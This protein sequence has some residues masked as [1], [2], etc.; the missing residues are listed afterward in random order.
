MS[1]F[2][3]LDT[4]DPIELFAAQIRRSRMAVK[5]AYDEAFAAWDRRSE[6]LRE[7]QLSSGYG[8]M[9]PPWLEGYG[10]RPPL[11]QVDLDRMW[12]DAVAE[13]V[14]ADMQASLVVL[15][16]DDALQRLMRGLLG[17]ERRPEGYGPEYGVPY[18]GLV[19]LTVLL[20]AGSNS[21]RHVSEWDD[22][23]WNTY[24]PW[25][26]ATGGVYPTLDE[27]KVLTKIAR[28]QRDIV[29]RMRL[30]MQSIDVF[31]RVFG[32]GVNKRIR[33]P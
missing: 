5:S 10:G 32:I 2:I 22:L 18:K 19:K 23:P 33:D 1:G 24:Y 11:A 7:H 12:D 17:D 20:R 30:A 21:V 6:L 31:Q 25:P 13:N 27:C 29:E 16:T 3:K 14:Q 26:T 9:D 15:V 28:A 4:L 8:G